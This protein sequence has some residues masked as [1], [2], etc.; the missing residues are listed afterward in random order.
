MQRVHAVAAS[1]AA[2]VPFLHPTHPTAYVDGAKRPFAHCTHAPT[3]AYIPLSHATHA[4]APCDDEVAL[5]TVPETHSAHSDA[6]FAP[7]KRPG[8]HTVVFEPS[9]YEPLVHGA[10][11]K[12]P[13][14]GTAAGVAAGLATHV[15]DPRALAVK[16]PA[17]TKHADVP[18]AAYFPA[19]HSAH[20]VAPVLPAAG[21]AYRPA[22]H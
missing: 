1:F 9:Q 6:P 14:T 17:Q 13:G 19:A 16:P 15:G 12:R 7:A 10:L 3:L 21:V 8:G 11:A 4:V 18:A 22:A 20:A 2:N 5:A